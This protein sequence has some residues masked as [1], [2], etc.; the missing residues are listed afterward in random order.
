MADPSFETQVLVGL[1][2]IK[3]DV[4]AIKVTVDDSK[5]RLDKHETQIAELTKLQAVKD[6]VA[7]HDRDIELLKKFAY[8]GGGILVAITVAAPFVAPHLGG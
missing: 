3:G 7:E 6:A 5:M 8:R 1:E 2:E 4:K